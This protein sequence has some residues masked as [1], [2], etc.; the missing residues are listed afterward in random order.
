MAACFQ[1]EE[2]ARRDQEEYE[3]RAEEER[4]AGLEQDRRRAESR[5]QEEKKV[6]GQLL[7]QVDEL[8]ARESEV[9]LINII[10]AIIITL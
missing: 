1:R 6:K 2:Q 9:R 4:R 10:I 8:R 3:R 7:D 5:L